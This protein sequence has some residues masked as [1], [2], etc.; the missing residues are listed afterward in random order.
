MHRPSRAWRTGK[1]A[2]RGWWGNKPPARRQIVVIGVF[3]SAL[4]FACGLFL[5]RNSLD[6]DSNFPSLNSF[7]WDMAKLAILGTL[8]VAIM[9]D[10]RSWGDR[11]EILQINARSIATPVDELLVMFAKFSTLVGLGAAWVANLRSQ[12]NRPRSSLDGSTRSKI[13]KMTSSSGT[14]ASIPFRAS[15]GSTSAL[16]T[17]TCR[18]FCRPS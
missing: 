10:I 5:D 1:R 11:W 14:R 2:T 12:R 18:T 6:L 4:L 16:Q 8:V 17:L 7:I 3:A 9:D 13:G 15:S